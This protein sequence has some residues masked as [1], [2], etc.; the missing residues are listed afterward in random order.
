MKIS[1]GN[2]RAVLLGATGLVGSYVLENL[3]L[4]PAY[5]EVVVLG[6]RKVD[7]E[8]PRLQQH[9][10]DFE[11]LA[12]HAGLLRGDDL[13]CCLGTTRRQAGSREAFYRVDFT[14]SFEAA[15]IAAANQM[16]QLLVVSSVGADK[17]SLFYYSRVKGEL[18]EALQELDFWSLHLFQPSVLLG[19]R[20]ENRW[21]EQAAGQLGK[22]IDSITGGLLSKYRP[23]EAD[24]VARAMVTAAQELQ[25]GR[26]VYPSHQLQEIAE[27]EQALL[28]K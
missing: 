21:G 5:A 28:K 1:K 12:D 20:N 17:D 9:Q 23:I 7:L 25:G 18:E 10:V 8:H 26:H 6:R 24:I 3:L 16:N 4:H 22:W 14:Y 2:K 27:R 19:S 15:R 11:R 13:F